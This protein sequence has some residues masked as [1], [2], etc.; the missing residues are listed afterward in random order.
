MPLSRY[1]FIVK[2][3]GYSPNDHSAEVSS[4]QFSTKV[5]GVS[6]LSSAIQ[7][8]RRLVASGVQLIE[9]C[10]GFGEDE[11][12][13]LRVQIEFKVPVGVVTYSK[14]QTDEL[15]RILK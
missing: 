14:E 9:L 13:H 4:Q 6:N 2:A 1:A 8:A 7:V 5:V 10:G 12:Q 15:D 11:A 3:P